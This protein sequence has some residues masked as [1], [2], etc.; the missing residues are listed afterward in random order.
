[1]VYMSPIDRIKHRTDAFEVLGVSKG[2]TLEEIKCAYR[3]LVFEV[4][5]DKNP[6]GNDAFIRISQAYR[7][8]CE[9]AN[10]LGPQVACPR[11]RIFPKRVAPTA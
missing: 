4:H 11:P 6:E 9:N 3:K 5:P 10:D 8:L 7:Y 2:A 1:M